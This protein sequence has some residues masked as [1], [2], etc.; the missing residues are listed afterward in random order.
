MARRGRSDLSVTANLVSEQLVSVSELA[1]RWQ[2]DRHT[3]VRLLEDAGVMP[4]YL[5]RKSRG[6]RRY[7]ARDVDRFLETSQA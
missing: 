6:T 1:E 3:V 7:L 4:L 2:V 5:S